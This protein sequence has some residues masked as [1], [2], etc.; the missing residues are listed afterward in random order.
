MEHSYFALSIADAGAGA[1]AVVVAVFSLTDC[2]FKYI[3]VH[4]F[5]EARARTSE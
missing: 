4:R 5:Q 3:F 2:N 1:G